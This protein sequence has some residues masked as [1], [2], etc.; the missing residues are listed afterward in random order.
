MWRGKKDQLTSVKKILVYMDNQILYKWNSHQT[1]RRK[2]DPCALAVMTGE[3]S[4][5]IVE[6]TVWGAGQALGWEQYPRGDVS[7]RGLEG[8]WSNLPV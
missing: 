7:P 3:S 6:K 1:N 4:K 8:R 2:W 5:V